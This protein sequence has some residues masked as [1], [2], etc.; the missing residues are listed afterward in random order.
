MFADTFQPHLRQTADEYLPQTNNKDEKNLKPVIPKEVASETD[1][2]LSFKKAPGCDLV[3]R[4]IM[5]K[6]RTK[7]IT[8]LTRLFTCIMYQCSG[9]WQEVIVIQEPGCL[10]Y[11]SRCV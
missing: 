8:D 2:N 3:T 4:Q 9:K 6:L 10:L 7:G 11:T 5:K 1:K